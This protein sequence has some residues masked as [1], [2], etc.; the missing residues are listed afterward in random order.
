M[1]S[2]PEEVS[3]SE[4]LDLFQEPKD[5]YAPAKPNTFTT[6]TTKN[7]TELTLRL[8]GHNPLWGHLLWNAGQI[9]ARYL[10]DNVT[11]VVKDKTVLELGAGAGLPSL[12]CALHGAKRVVVTDYPDPDLIENLQYNIDHSIDSSYRHLI[13]AQGL[14]WGGDVEPLKGQLENPDGFDLLI[15]ADI[16]FNHSEHGHLIKTLQQTLRRTHDAQALVF[17]T[18]YRPWLLEKDMNFFD[19]AR[20]AGFQVRKLFEHIMDKVMFPDDAGDETLR[21]TVFAYEITWSI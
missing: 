11:R 18:P 13:A 20:S 15:L 9:V 17:F 10:E 5:Y 12:I 21:R 16:L 6:Y 3:D 7:G 19:L 14:L 2:L 1:S 8:V 4:E